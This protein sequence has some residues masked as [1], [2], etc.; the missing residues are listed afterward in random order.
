MKARVDAGLYSCRR[1]AIGDETYFT[2]TYGKL[3]R[4]V[5]DV[6]WESSWPQDF[7]KWI[8]PQI[9]VEPTFAAC[10]PNKDDA[11]DAILGLDHPEF[12]I[13]RHPG[14]GCRS[15]QHIDEDDDTGKPAAPSIP[16]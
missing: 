15:E 5:A 7:R 4:G 11:M 10:R 16:R 3:Q 13:N 12:M 1:R 14:S 9:F 2:F 6:Y 8:A